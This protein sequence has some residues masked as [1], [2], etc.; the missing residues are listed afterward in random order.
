M[1]KLRYWEILIVIECPVSKSLKYETI[2][3]H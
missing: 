3:I 1:Y 2:I